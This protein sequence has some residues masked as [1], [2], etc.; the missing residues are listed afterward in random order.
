MGSAAYLSDVL[1]EV[2][3]HAVDGLDSARTGNPAPARVLIAHGPPAVDACE[4]DG[5]LAAY[6]DGID[7]EYLG[8]SGPPGNCAAIAAANVVIEV[9][10]C[11]PTVTDQG[12]PPDPTDEN[13][14]AVAL[15]ADAWCLLTYIT[16]QALGGTLVS[17]AGCGNVTL[18]SLEV[19]EPEGGVAGIRLPVTVQ[20]TDGG[21]AIGS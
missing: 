10:R 6:Y 1:G 5:L 14:A 20:L 16:I 3:A 8:R 18:G 12:D 15:A 19:L 17:G 2:L 11:Y 4:D 21:P 13:A 9:W 7:V